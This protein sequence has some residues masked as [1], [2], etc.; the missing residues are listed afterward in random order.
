MKKKNNNKSVIQTG[1][2]IIIK[3]D[4]DVVDYDDYLLNF[5]KPE[6]GN[7]RLR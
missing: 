7:K 6:D 1:H 4:E 2:G 3:G 5:E